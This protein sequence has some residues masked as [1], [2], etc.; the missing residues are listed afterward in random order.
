[1]WPLAKAISLLPV[2]REKILRRND[3]PNDF[4]TEL[5]SERVN[6]Y[7]TIEVEVSS[8]NSSPVSEFAFLPHDDRL[9][10]FGLEHQR[11][12]LKNSQIKQTRQKALSTNF[13]ASVVVPANMKT[14]SV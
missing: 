14:K 12:P 11:G 1:M 6:N 7:R 2:V 13:P 5:C 10:R 3:I 4:C 9:W 8:T